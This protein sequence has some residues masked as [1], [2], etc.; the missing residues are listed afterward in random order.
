MH[1]AEAVAQRPYAAAGSRA[2]FKDHYAAA[3][4]LQ[5][6]RGSKPRES[7]AHDDNRWSRHSPISRPIF[8]RPV[9]NRQ[10]IY[11]NTPAASVNKGSFSA[12]ALTCLN[13]GTEAFSLD[14]GEEPE[15]D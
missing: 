7:R 13:L 9:M 15:G 1:S 14:S 4:L 5:D 6:A 12:S 2:R 3:A 10:F 11:G 8:V